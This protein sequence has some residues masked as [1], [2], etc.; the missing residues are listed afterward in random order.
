MSI[1]PPSTC[2]ASKTVAPARRVPARFTEVSAGSESHFER[3]A[4][5]VIKGRLEHR[6][7]AV[8]FTALS[9]TKPHL[10]ISTEE[11]LRV[12]LDGTRL[13]PENIRRLKQILGANHGPTSV[14]V[15]TESDARSF[16]LGPEFNVNTLTAVAELRAAFGQN[17]VAN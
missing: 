4:I 1:L 15:E 8:R 17:V 14:I 10:V 12:R 5:V 9:I 11:V 7:E 13:N 2:P 3:D 16:R 6:D